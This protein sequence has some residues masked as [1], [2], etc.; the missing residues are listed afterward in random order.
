MTTT[1]ILSTPRPRGHRLPD[2]AAI[3]LGLLPAAGL[4][5]IFFGLPIVQGILISFSRWPGIGSVH[6]S[7]LQSYRLVLQQPQIF[8]S[9]WLTFIYAFAT[10]TL[11][12]A[13]ATLL[14]T[15]ISSRVPGSSFYRF[16]W[17][18][19]AMAPVVA[20]GIYWSSAMQ[21]TTGFVN[22]VLG[23]VGLGDAHTWLSQPNI[24][25]YPC[26]FASVWAG[27][28][29]AFIL[30]L[31]ATEQVP[32]ALYEAAQLDGASAVRR[33]FSVTL[34]MVRPVIGVVAMLEFIWAANGFT[35]L[36]AMT[37]GGPGYATSI[38]SVLIYREGFVLS[39]YG[40]S[41]AMAVLG[42]IVLVLIG[43]LMLRLSRSSHEG[44]A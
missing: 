25:I 37:R 29:I 32:V 42:G 30:I 24:A 16:V 11:M 27:A 43:S 9:L 6:L 41:A 20:V 5:A 1:T 36:W 18:L 40:Q 12:T 28:G 15:A 23:Y 22:I 13:I 10:S 21:P 31:G 8:H 19:P 26:V 7:G 14:A 33:F 44:A 17:F 2:R 4:M 39:D 34:P 3:W 38:L 35:L